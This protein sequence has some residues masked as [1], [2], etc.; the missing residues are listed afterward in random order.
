MKRDTRAK[1]TQL[2]TLFALGGLVANA[3]DDGFLAPFTNF[4]LSAALN[5]AA[6]HRALNYILKKDG[7]YNLV[8]RIVARFRQR[9][10]AAEAANQQNLA[11]DLR[12]ALAALRCL[13]KY[14]DRR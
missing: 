4:N 3:D 5:D 14:L 9:L 2:A 12:Q 6:V 1:T 10:A 7:G 11:A 8:T 13:D